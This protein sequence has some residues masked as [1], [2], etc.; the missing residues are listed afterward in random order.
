MRG[1]GR[2]RGIGFAIPNGQ[3]PV[4]GLSQ[5]VAS[6]PERFVAPADLRDKGMQ[7]TVHRGGMGR[8][9]CRFLQARSG[10]LAVAGP[11]GKPGMLLRYHPGI[12]IGFAFFTLASL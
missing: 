9:P 4:L 12:S 1:G 6:M 11:A 5:V 3:G 10:L 7:C 2:T 8:C